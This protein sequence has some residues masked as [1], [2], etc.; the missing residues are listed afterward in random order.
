MDLPLMVTFAPGSVVPLMYVV[1]LLVRTSSAVGGS[2]TWRGGGTESLVPLTVFWT[3]LRAWECAQQSEQIRLPVRV[4][5]S[6]GWAAVQS[7]AQF[8][9]PPW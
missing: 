5:S 6:L 9:H 7:V 3:Q 8:F 4:R 2:V 1:S